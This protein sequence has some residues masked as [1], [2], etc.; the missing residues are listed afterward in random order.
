MT[1]CHLV[2]MVFACLAVFPCLSCVVGD[3]FFACV[4]C[5]SSLM[6]LACHF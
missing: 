4:C 3:S 5:K 6:M 2:E 1:A